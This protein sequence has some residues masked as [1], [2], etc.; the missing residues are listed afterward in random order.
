[1]AAPPRQSGWEDLRKDLIAEL[2]D[3]PAFTEA[4][5]LLWPVLTPQ[6]LLSSLYSSCER[7][8]AAGADPALFRIDGAAWTV[9]DIPRNCPRW[10]GGS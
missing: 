6:D 3:H 1:M 8:R 4:L 2:A 5:D 9:S 10:T 7:L